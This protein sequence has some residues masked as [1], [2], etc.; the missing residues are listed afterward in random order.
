MHISRNENYSCWVHEI[1]E[2]VQNFHTDL[3]KLHTREEHCL[4]WLPLSLSL[5]LLEWQG[6]IPRMNTNHVEWSICARS[7]VDSAQWDL[8]ITR[9]WINILPIWYEERLWIDKAQQ[10]PNIDVEYL[11]SWYKSMRTRFGKLSRLP[12]WVR[13]PRADRNGWRDTPQL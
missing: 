2:H 13:C 7:A 8:G 4:N 5:S 9:S 12:P 11:M 10:L 3:L 1:F 6:I